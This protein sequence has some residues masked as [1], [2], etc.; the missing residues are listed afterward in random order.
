MLVAA[1]AFLEALPSKLISGTPFPSASLSA[2]SSN[3]HPQSQSMPCNDSAIPTVDPITISELSSVEHANY[4]F[5]YS[6]SECNGF[7]C[8]S[9][10][11]YYFDN[12]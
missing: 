1:S 5:D 2:N 7:G 12:Y 4:S 9:T 8:T 10:Q 3:Q 6:I 11:S